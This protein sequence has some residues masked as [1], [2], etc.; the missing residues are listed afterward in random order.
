LRVT[1]G[2]RRFAV[3]VSI[4]VKGEET[5]DESDAGLPTMKGGWVKSSQP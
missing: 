5:R 1:R 2:S 3:L 4:S